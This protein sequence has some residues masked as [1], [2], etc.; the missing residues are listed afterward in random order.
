MKTV[1]Y[2][3]VPQTVSVRKYEVDITGLQQLLREHKNLTNKEIAEKLCCP[4][5]KVEHW[6]RTDRFFA[7]PDPELW[8]GLKKLLNIQ[9]DLF[10]KAVMEFEERDG[11]F[12][13][14]ERIYLSDYLCPTLTTLCEHEKVLV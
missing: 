9:T 13:K 6:F 10:D 5:T 4:L 3:V 8:L 1:K 2:L 14:N 12:D 7:I 11:V